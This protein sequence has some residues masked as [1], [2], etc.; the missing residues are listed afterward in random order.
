[1]HLR[2]LLASVFVCTSAV[3]GAPADA[4]DSSN[5]ASAADQIVRL[6]D[7]KKADELGSWFAGNVMKSP[8][9]LRVWLTAVLRQYGHLSD[10]TLDPTLKLEDYTEL[11]MKSKGLEKPFE[12]Y[13]YRTHYQ[14]EGD[15][16]V[17]VQLAKSKGQCKID[18]L[19]FG[20]PRSNP[21]ALKRY[22]ELQVRIDAEFA[23]LF[24]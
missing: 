10:T 13:K 17:Y 22:Y 4:Q 7:E 20:L 6:V 3:F 5:C 16:I 18:Y 21:D 19:V 15:G 11:G 1:M 12:V 2:T 8:G 23:D 9:Y 24:R 14:Y